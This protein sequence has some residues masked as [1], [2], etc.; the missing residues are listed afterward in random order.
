M[1]VL[2]T[3]GAGYIGRICSELLV[4]A[5]VNVIALDNLSEGH[6]GAVPPQALFYEA[7]FGN[8]VA[9]DE[10]FRRH[11]IDAVIHFAGEALV[12]KSMKDP[13]PFY[14]TWAYFP[15]NSCLTLEPAPSALTMRSR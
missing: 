7:D 13:S 9:L 4:S 12:E 11:R 8:P 1:H 3:G 5:G 14:E 15:R 10:I 2:I 6:R